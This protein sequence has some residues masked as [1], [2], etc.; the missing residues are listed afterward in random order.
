[1]NHLQRQQL[2]RK[3]RTV[4][5]RAR[6]RGTAEKPRVHVFRS[7]RFCSVQVIDDAAGLTVCSITPTQLKKADQAGTK[8]EIATR[9]G[10]LVAEKMRAA[11]I[12][13]AIF[14][15]GPYTYHGRVR[16]VAEAIR[17]AGITI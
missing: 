5:V 2:A 16:A 11:K 14:D 3:R 1:M 6:V 7:N 12:T 17:Q 9:M 15:R 4:R 13:A 10:A 8:T